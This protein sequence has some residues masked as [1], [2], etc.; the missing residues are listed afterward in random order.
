[1]QQATQLRDLSDFVSY[2]CNSG[3]DNAATNSLAGAIGTAGDDGAGASTAVV[4]AA[5]TAANPDVKFS[6]ESAMDYRRIA[7]A[8][9]FIDDIKAGVPRTV[10]DSLHQWWCNLNDGARAS[11]C[12]LGVARL[13]PQLP[14]RTFTHCRH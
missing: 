4:A 7:A 9:R 8:F 2:T 1:M 11:A 14:F 5:A 12:L 6:Y 13:S 10:S 3:S